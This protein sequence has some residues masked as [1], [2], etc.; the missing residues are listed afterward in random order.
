MYGMR[1]YCCR[2]LVLSKQNNA[3]QINILMSV[4]FMGY[5]AAR[6]S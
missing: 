4:V 3:I 5:S 6:E 2:F 1:F